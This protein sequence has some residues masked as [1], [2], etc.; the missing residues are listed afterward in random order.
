MMTEIWWKVFLASIITV[1]VIKLLGIST[2]YLKIFFLA[3]GGFAVGFILLA[4]VSDFIW[5]KR[6]NRRENELNIKSIYSRVSSRINIYHFTFKVWWMDNCHC[7]SF[8]SNHLMDCTG[9][10]RYSWPTFEEKEMSYL[11]RL[12]IS[13]FFRPSILC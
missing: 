8:F 7:C 4:V 5:R 2:S 9:C 6:K 13:S 11:L 1:V 12:F 10:Y 3:F